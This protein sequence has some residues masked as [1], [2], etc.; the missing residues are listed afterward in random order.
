MNKDVVVNILFLEEVQY[1]EEISEVKGLE[2]QF[3]NVR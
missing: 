2:R 3:L 1:V